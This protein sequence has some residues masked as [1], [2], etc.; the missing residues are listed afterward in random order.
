MAD[1]KPIEFPEELKRHNLSEQELSPL[2]PQQQ[3][4]AKDWNVIKRQMEWIINHDVMLHNILVDHDKK[5][6]DLWFWFK[7]VTILTGGGGSLIGIITWL[8][9]ASGIH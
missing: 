8:T 3:A 4:L 9:K 5:L 1:L 7:V 6:E 2:T